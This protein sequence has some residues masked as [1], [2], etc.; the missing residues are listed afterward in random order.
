MPFYCIDILN[1][2]KSTTNVL[3]LDA[4]IHVIIELFKLCTKHEMNKFVLH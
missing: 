3:N 2:S 4:M 1:A